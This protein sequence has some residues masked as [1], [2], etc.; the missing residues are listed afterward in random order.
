MGLNDY[1]MEFCEKHGYTGTISINNS[2]EYIVQMENGLE[3]SQATL[4]KEEYESATEDEIK[5]LLRFMRNGMELRTRAR[6]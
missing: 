6:T 5:E 4:T 3:C 1:L 2:G